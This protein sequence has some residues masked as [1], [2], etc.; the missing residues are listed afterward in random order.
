MDQIDFCT[1]GMF[2]IDEV[3]FLPPTP[4]V[5]DIFGGAASFAAL[6]ARIFS[7]PPLSKSVGWIV[8]CGYDF[9]PELR[10][11]IDQWQTSC[12]MREQPDMPT[13]RGWNGY[14]ENEHREFKFLTD[15]IRLWHTDLTPHLL[16]SKTHHLICHPARL[17][18]MVEGI[19][20]RRREELADKSLPTPIFVWEPTPT[21]CLPSELDECRKVL[22]LVHVVSPNHA[23]LT[24]FFGVPGN[25]EDKVNRTAVEECA[26]DWIK[27][28]I[29]PD[30]S[31]AIV[32]RAGKEGC[33]VATAKQQEW[34]PAVHQHGNGKVVDPTGGGNAFLGGL[35]VAL[36]RGHDIEEAAVWGSIAASFAIENVGMPVLTEHKDE[37]RWNGERVQDRIESFKRQL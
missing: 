26:A 24:S 27:A 10:K 4:P 28:G 21:F 33:Y 11:A 32:V 16:A 31:G 12:L 13:V 1:L 37:E 25:I 19:L 29:G 23:E 7:P 36:A 14:G 3:H 5:K 30:G 17:I 22:K 2:V 8:D 35:G 18:I 34:L 15:R 20:T 6:G 9:P